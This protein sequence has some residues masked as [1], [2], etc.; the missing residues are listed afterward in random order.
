MGKVCSK[1]A[2]KWSS[3]SDVSK[4]KLSALDLRQVAFELQFQCLRAFSLKKACDD[5]NSE[6]RICAS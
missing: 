4:R 3:H 1:E 2:F 5:N 6:E